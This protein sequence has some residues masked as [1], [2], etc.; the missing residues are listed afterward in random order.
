VSGS[1]G[2]LCSD[3]VLV[4]F[5]EGK[6]KLH[7][8]PGTV[9]QDGNAGAPRSNGCAVDVQGRPAS[10]QGNWYLTPPRRPARLDRQPAGR[11]ELS[12]KRGQN[13]PLPRPPLPRIGSQAGRDVRAR[14]PGGQTPA[15]P[16]LL[17][18]R[19]ARAWIR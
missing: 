6:V 18:I 12:P 9:L 13:C 14:G 1:N 15:E 16:L 10:E 19:L 4:G 11:L 2:Q 5:S 17:A 7:H 3:G 8:S